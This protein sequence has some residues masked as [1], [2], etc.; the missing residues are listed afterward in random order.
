MCG[1]FSLT[2]DEQQLNLF[3][4]LSGG[5][6]PYVPRYNGAPTQQLAV[7]TAEE[8]KRLQFFRW[9][10]I[11]KWSKE[12][13]KIP[14]IN[15]RSETIDQ[16]PSFKNIFKERR[17]LVPA[18]G[19]YE[20]VHT[21]KKL[22]YRFTLTDEKVFAFAGLWDSWQGPDS[23]ILNSFSI[24]TTEANSIMETIHD[25]MPVILDKHQFEPWLNEKDMSV[26]KNMLKP[27]DS[28]RMQ[29]YR[30]PETINKA[31]AEGPELIIACEP[32]DFFSGELF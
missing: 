14:I 18:D 12:M 29:K 8:P 25:R 26:V 19:F 16:K 7:I 11:P 3:F 20:W 1:R 17:C 13:P 21:G 6:A 30:V 24:L 4:E 5:S 23:K 27:F 28:N 32:L 2:T 31:T 10:L 22:P 9:G 15:A